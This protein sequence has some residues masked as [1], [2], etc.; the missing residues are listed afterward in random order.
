MFHAT[1]H[2]YGEQEEHLGLPL[3]CG[4][5]FLHIFLGRDEDSSNTHIDW[6][7]RPFSLVRFHPENDFTLGDRNFGDLKSD[8]PYIC[9]REAATIALEKDT[10]ISV[11]DVELVAANGGNEDLRGEEELKFVLHRILCDFREDREAGCP[12]DPDH[13]EQ[14]NIGGKTKNGREAETGIS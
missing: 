7:F 8:V 11:F 6:V 14:D 5:D 4:H 13:H 3:L 1:P 12:R 10:Q 9:M 2:R